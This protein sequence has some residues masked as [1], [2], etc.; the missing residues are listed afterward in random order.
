MAL[1]VILHDQESLTLKK[2]H[3]KF[4][5]G[6]GGELTITYGRD[7]RSSRTLASHEWRE[8]AEDCEPIL[9]SNGA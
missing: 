5:V 7:A 3:D 4:S 9:Q 2:G 1:T 6:T 8:V